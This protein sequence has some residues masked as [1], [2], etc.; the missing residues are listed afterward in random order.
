M[1][2]TAI[3]SFVH[4]PSKIPNASNFGLTFDPPQPLR[5]MLLGAARLWL[6]QFCYQQ[7]IVHAP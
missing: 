1:C 4:V 3:K 6:V 2:T 7:I 5:S